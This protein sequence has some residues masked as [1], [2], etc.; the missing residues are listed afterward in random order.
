MT[1]R[2][3]S[4]FDLMRE[5]MERFEEMA[6]EIFEEAFGKPSWDVDSRTLKPLSD[7]TVTPR[8]VIITVDL[9]FAKPETVRINWVREDMIEVNA[10][11]RTKVR[12]EDLGVSHRE[13][14]FSSFHC[15]IQLPVPVENREVKISFKRGIL[16]IRLPRKRG[17][18]IRVE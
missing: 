5:Y 8:E 6:E 3:R 9:P 10:K 18:R 13:G 16:E 11:M 2:R 14:E 7:I 15:P 12:F 1:W 17:Y 4:I